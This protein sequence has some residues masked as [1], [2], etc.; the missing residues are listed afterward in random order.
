MMMSKMKIML[1]MK[2][3]TKMKMK[4]NLRDWSR[5]RGAPRGQENWSEV[6]AENKVHHIT[7][8]SV[9]ICDD[10]HDDDQEEDDEED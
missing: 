9:Y 1:K 3:K 4:M 5:Q 8:I 6:Q 10:N 7:I 2:M